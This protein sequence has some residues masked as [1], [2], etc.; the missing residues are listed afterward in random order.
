M[1]PYYSEKGTNTS[2]MVVNDLLQQLNVE[3]YPTQGYAND[4]MVVAANI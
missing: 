1:K 4:V 3:R 2:F